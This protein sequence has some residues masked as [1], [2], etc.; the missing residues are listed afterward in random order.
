MA[1]K[2]C[3]LAAVTLHY[4]LFDTTQC[5]NNKTFFLSFLPLRPQNLL[6]IMINNVVMR[7]RFCQGRVSQLL[8]ISKRFQISAS[9]CRKYGSG[10]D[11]SC[12]TLLRQNLVRF[13]IS[14]YLSSSL[15]LMKLQLILTLAFFLLSCSGGP[16][17]LGLAGLGPPGALLGSFHY[18]KK[19]KL[20][21]KVYHAEQFPTLK[22]SLKS[23]P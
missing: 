20:D 21:F 6:M 15:G 13:I 19:S 1:K 9:Q 23:H 5:I 2:L 11:R 8:T 12:L 3:F 14:C 22:R 17:L 4:L 18:K 10:Y 16:D 7:F